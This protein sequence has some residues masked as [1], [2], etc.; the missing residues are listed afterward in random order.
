VNPE[1]VATILWIAF[2]VAI[3]LGLVSIRVTDRN[4]SLVAGIV[5]TAVLAGFSWLAGFSIGPFT[6][7]LPVLL[8]ATIISRGAALLVRILVVVLAAGVYWLVTW[9]SQ[10]FGTWWPFILPGLCA[11]AYLAVFL[12]FRLRRH[13]RPA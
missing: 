11:L 1:L 9:R 2:A 10:Q 6:I 5:S 13:D 4:I 7:A 8:T 3:V 12:R